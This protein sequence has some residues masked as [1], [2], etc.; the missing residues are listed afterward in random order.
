MARKIRFPLEMKNGV[1]VRSLEEFIENFDIDKVLLYIADGKL[2]RWLRD[3]SREDLAD[4][5]SQLP[6]N[7]DNSARAKKICHIFNVPEEDITVDLEVA[8]IR[9]QHY[10]L[11]K[12]FTDDKE[13]LDAFD[14]VAFTQDDVHRI[15]NDGKKKIYLFREKFEIPLQETNITYVGLDNPTVSIPIDSLEEWKAKNIMVENCQYDEKYNRLYREYF[16][17][18]AD[19]F[20]SDAVEANSLSPVEVFQLV[21]NEMKQLPIDLKNY[22][23]KVG[24]LQLGNNLYYVEADGLSA[25]WGPEQDDFDTEDNSSSEW[26]L[27]QYNFDTK[28]VYKILKYDGKVKKLLCIRN[29]ILFSSYY[30]RLQSKHKLCTLNLETWDK[31]EYETPYSNFNHKIW[32]DTVGK[33][34][35]FAMDF[36]GVTEYDLAS[37]NLKNQFTLKGARKGARITDNKLIVW[38]YEIE[39]KDYCLYMDLNSKKVTKIECDEYTNAVLKFHH[40]HPI[41]VSCFN[42]KLYWVQARTCNTTDADSIKYTLAI[43]CI[44]LATN[45]FHKLSETNYAWDGSLYAAVTKFASIDIRNGWIYIYESK[46]TLM[47]A[48]LMEAINGVAMGLVNGIQEMWGLSGTS[49]KMPK[50]SKIS[51]VKAGLP[52][53]RVEIDTGK[54]ERLE[55]NTFVPI[56]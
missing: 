22:Q 26:W 13:I 3:R 35:Y 11:L 21:G 37:G 46:K 19:I 54:I 7:I 2:E 23:R 9:N 38:G 6:I 20:V 56:D 18:R 52:I 40:S 14:S 44:D 24:V 25:E 1:M 32:V 45:K 8:K 55:N 4:A 28:E 49:R 51:V 17:E 47:G 30:H 53:L 48:A 34:S 50:S 43:L 15:L 31:K 36:D 41:G 10:N 42:N 39:D 12:Q 29:H 33:I 16:L 27:K 5:I